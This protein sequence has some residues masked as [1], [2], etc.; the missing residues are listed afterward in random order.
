MTA[1]PITVA[2]DY[3][4]TAPLIRLLGPLEMAGGHPPT[5][6]KPRQVLA[7]LASQPGQ[8][9]SMA[10]FAEE[11][12]ADT[13][14]RKPNQS[15][16]TY[17]YRIKQ[18]HG[19][20]PVEH[21][22]QGYILN[23]NPMDVDALRFVSFADQAAREVVAGRLVAAQ[24]TLRAAFSLWRGS[25]L[26]DVARGPLLSRWAAGIVDRHRTAR[27]LGFEIDLRLGRHREVLDGLRHELRA[28]WTREDIAQT[29]MTA[30]C[31]SQRRVEAL[32]VYRTVREAH[33][34]KSRALTHVRSWRGCS[35]RSCR[36]TRHSN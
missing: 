35:S 13:G 11:L 22:P 9:V 20:L 28:D 30:L 31:R 8:R 21:R 16:E 17:I 32:N 26:E 2:P 6:P 10:A 18:D 14:I 23:V 15:V 7:L 29:L 24:D 33:W 4:P 1:Q 36:G 34:R 27:L 5:A 25:V 12:W 3:A 19:C